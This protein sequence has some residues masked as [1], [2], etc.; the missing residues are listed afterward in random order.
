MADA[1]GLVIPTKPMPDFKES[2]EEMVSLL[3]EKMK[4]DE[5][6]NEELIDQ[7][8]DQQKLDKRLLNF[9]GKRF[10]RIRR[11]V[12]TSRDKVAMYFEKLRKK[13]WFEKAGTMFKKFTQKAGNW[14]FGLL[15]ILFFL[16][17][18]DPKGKFLT[19]ILKFIVKM[20]VKLI[21]VI[22]KMLPTVLR[23]MWKLISVT[24]PKLLANAIS[25][26]F[27]AIGRAIDKI[28]EGTTL[29]GLGKK[30]FGSQGY[31]TRFFKFLV[32]N[33]PIILGFMAAMVI[34]TKVMAAWTVLSITWKKMGTILKFING[35]M[36]TLVSKL[37]P[38]FVTGLKGM[39]GV[40]GK[41][42]MRI[43]G[44][45]TALGKMGMA[46]KA[47][48]GVKLGI[49]GLV[50]G[51]LIAWY[52][53]AERLIKSFRKDDEEYAKLL[54]RREGISKKRA[55]IQAK[56]MGRTT[57][58]T[59][60]LLTESISA[61]KKKGFKGLLDPFKDQLKLNKEASKLKWKPDSVMKFL[62]NIKS[63]VTNFFTKTIPKVF[64]S[65]FK[66]GKNI[67]S[68]IGSFFSK[69][70]SSITGIFKKIN[71]GGFGK[72]FKN[73][74]RKAVES[75]RNFVG[76]INIGGFFSKLIR[77]VK[78]W[79]KRLINW[80]SLMF[81]NFTELFKPGGKRKIEVGARLKTVLGEVKGRNEEE[82]I[83]RATKILAPRIGAEKARKLLTDAMNGNLDALHQLSKKIGDLGTFEKKA[84]GRSAHFDVG[85]NYRS[86]K[87]K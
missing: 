27:P 61:F 67:V 44:V 85:E 51:G 15:K 40:F 11:A 45:G 74:I 60:G 64:K 80:V 36:F 56:I 46:L 20:A 28:F 58:G 73:A 59:F 75:I 32:G 77:K 10:P 31:L 38:N 5:E 7:G 54:R 65:F 49:I 17:I 47:L 30:L 78:S 24:I 87:K 8:E 52:K 34:R 14:L 2:L 72:I 22:A 33:L 37:F 68:N 6:Q 26:I 84:T 83:R 79:F 12:K 23:T 29:E 86:K 81:R 66:K 50:I 48:G 76:K 1:A 39:G 41:L 18:F 3:Q 57:R 63:T 13:K 62:M 19:S 9:M 53:N 16:A 42:I 82:R 21:G 71:I 55:M 43:P 25:Q 70:G 35:K 69:L 4:K